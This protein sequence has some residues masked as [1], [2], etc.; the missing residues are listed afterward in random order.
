[1]VPLFLGAGADIAYIEGIRQA[2]QHP[3]LS[4]A[5]KTSLKEAAALLEK[6]ELVVGSDTALTHIGV[7]L[8]RPVVAIFGPTGVNFEPRGPLVEVIRAD[9]DCS[10][11]WSRPQCDANYKCMSGVEVQRVISAIRRLISPRR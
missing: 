9:C 4:L 7:A 10:P 6:S 2:C 3:T 1:M 5:G 8:G 11:C